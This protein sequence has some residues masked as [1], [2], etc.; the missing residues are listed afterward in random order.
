MITNLIQKLLKKNFLTIP[1]FVPLTLI[2]PFSG[3]TF[4]FSWGRH[5][6]DVTGIACIAGD[7]V[8]STVSQSVL[9]LK[10]L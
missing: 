1:Y 3:L 4:S 2:N 10:P 5:M 9:G 8:K 6:A 7:L